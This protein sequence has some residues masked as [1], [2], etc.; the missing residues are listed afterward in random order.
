MNPR[1]RIFVVLL[2][3][4]LLAAVPSS[5]AAASAC[6]SDLPPYAAASL[7]TTAPVSTWQQGVPAGTVDIP[8]LG[9][10]GVDQWQYKV[11]C[12][13]PVTII[14]AGGNAAVVGDGTHRFT[15]RAHDSVSGA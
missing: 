1:I 14:G 15:H 12:G 8:L 9:G 6:G 5:A 4:A 13:A 11:D 7:D 3:L 10:A 2:A